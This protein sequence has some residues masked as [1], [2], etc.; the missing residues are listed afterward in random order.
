[1]IETQA[2]VVRLES[3]HA[4]VEPRPHTPCGQCDPVHGCRSL[5]IARMFRAG[6]SAFRVQNPLDAAVGDW[7]TVSIPERGM[8]NSALLMYLVP[9]AGLFVGAAAGAL[10]SETV[11]VLAGLAGFA[12]ALLAV[13]RVSR[14][15]G[16]R[17]LFQPV[18][19]ERLDVLASTPERPCRSKS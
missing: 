7:V 12:A 6:S 13:R 3:S 16:Q 17:A 4:W 8:L 19:T 15:F 2:R 5:S 14:G 18:I 9:L 1:M 11:S 10:A